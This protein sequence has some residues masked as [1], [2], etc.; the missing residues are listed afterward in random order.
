[1]WLLPTDG[2][3]DHP[4]ASSNFA[5][6]PV[7]S[8]AAIEGKLVVPHLG[9]NRYALSATAPDGTDWEQTTTLEGN[10][11][12]DAWVMEGATGLDTEFIVAGEPF[13]AIIFGYVSPSH[14]NG[15]NDPYT[16]GS[17]ARRSATITGTVD[18]VKVYVPA[19]GG[20]P[21]NAG[22]IWGGVSG[23]KIDK[24][25]DQPWLS[26]SN[27]GNGDT[28]VWIGRGNT[29]GKFTIPNVPDGTYTLTWWDDPQDYIMDLQNITV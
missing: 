13:P 18:A 28:A 7:P 5:E 29:D 9:T 21:N 25:I 14:T 26:L 16:Y 12:W 4:N 15:A 24:P 17:T 8:T 20:L 10:H 1:M 3:Y 23:S 2:R 22:Q 27:L 19:V 11:D 6:A